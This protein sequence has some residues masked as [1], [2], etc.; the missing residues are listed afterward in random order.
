MA[1]IDMKRDSADEKAEM[2]AY[3]ADGEGQYPYGLNICLDKDELDKLGITKLPPIGCEFHGIFVACVT[4]ISQ[5]A[6]IGMYDDS[7]SMSL[8]ITMLDLK[9]EAAH[10]GEESE[11]IKDVRKE[12]KTLLTDY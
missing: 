7:M 6:D 8:Q 3:P 11:T 9:E 10:P 5:T 12:F 2:D 4:R 1:L